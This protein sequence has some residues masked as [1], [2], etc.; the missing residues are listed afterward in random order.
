[1]CQADCAPGSK[2]T[3][4]PEKLAGFV[5]A[6]SGSMRALPV[7]KSAAPRTEGWAPAWVTICA[8]PS[9]AGAEPDDEQYRR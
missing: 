1:V 7:K 3:A 8:P 9:A 5:G 2:L 6:N 4:P